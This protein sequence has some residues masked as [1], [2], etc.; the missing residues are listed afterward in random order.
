VEID[1]DYAANSTA[2][3][4]FLS[5]AK[6]GGVATKKVRVVS[7]PIPDDPTT[8]NPEVRAVELPNT[9]QS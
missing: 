7:V 6:V 2:A 5:I 8:G 1:Q 9:P 3:K 4:V